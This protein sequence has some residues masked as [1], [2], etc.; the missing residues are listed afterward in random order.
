MKV[1]ENFGEFHGIE[2]LCIVLT[3]TNNA[4]LGSIE[5]L[6]NCK[7]LIHLELGIRSLMDQNLENIHLFLPN[8]KSFKSIY[9]T[10]GITDKTIINLSNLK[11][12][13]S[14]YLSKGFRNPI[15]FTYLIESCPKLQSISIFLSH[16]SNELFE[17]LIEKVF[18]N[19]KTHY[20]LKFIISF[21]CEFYQ[22]YLNDNSFP[23]NL[24]IN[25]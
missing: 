18:K 9:S 6:K 1:F 2:K 5:S 13:V 3:E 4:N 7:N 11:N 20:K 22:K 8:L 24:S 23:L 14:L 10:P 15:V 12:I 17:A 21:K 25:Q 19:P 16:I